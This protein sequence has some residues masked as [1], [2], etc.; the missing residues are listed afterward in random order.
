MNSTREIQSWQSYSNSLPVPQEGAQGSSESLR[1]IPEHLSTFGEGKGSGRG[2]GEKV[3]ER[4]SPRVGTARGL[5]H[6][7]RLSRYLRYRM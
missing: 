4:S 7:P 6:P 1:V 5:Q 3:A 2:P